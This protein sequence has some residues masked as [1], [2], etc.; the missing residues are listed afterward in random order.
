MAQINVVWT[1]NVVAHMESKS[2]INHRRRVNGS[3]LVSFYL[4]DNYRWLCGGNI[5]V[6]VS[7]DFGNVCINLYFCHAHHYS[8]KAP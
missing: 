3:H 7:H 2:Q 1:F 6:K 5:G 8:R 4:A